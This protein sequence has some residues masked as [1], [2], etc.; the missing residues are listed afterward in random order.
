MVNARSSR[1]ATYRNYKASCILCLKLVFYNF[2]HTLLSK[3]NHKASANSMARKNESH[4]LKEIATK[5]H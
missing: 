2:F 5:L 1:R 3:A 4:H